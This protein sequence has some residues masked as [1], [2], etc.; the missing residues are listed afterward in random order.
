MRITDLANY[1]VRTVYISSELRNKAAFPNGASFQFDLPITLNDLTGIALRDY[2]FAPEPLINYNNRTLSYTY[3]GAGGTASGSFTLPVGTPSG[4]SNLLVL[5]NTAMSNSGIGASFSQDSN[6]GLA[7]LSLSGGSTS[8]SFADSPLFLAMGYPIRTLSLLSSGSSNLAAGV[9]VGTAT[10]TSMPY[11][12]RPANMVLRIGDIETIVSN[13]PV[14]NRASAIL[15]DTTGSVS[16]GKQC[17]DHYIPLLQAQSRIQTLRIQLLDMN[18]DL[19]D[20]QNNEVSMLVEFYCK[21]TQFAENPAWFLES[22]RADGRAPR[23]V[24]EGRGYADAR[25]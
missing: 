25:G 22:A 2:N 9:Y 17:L 13:D 5:F 24:M 21:K 4:A 23:G 8:V 12:N 15:F 6:T 19:Y 1:D 18:G 10:G 7:T 14:T 20:T 11:V 3:T 16:V